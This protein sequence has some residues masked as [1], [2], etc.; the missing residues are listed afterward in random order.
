MIR[1]TKAEAEVI[2]DLKIQPWFAI[3]P[4]EIKDGSFILPDDVMEHVKPFLK[5][6]KAK[7]KIDKLELA[8]KDK[9]VRKLKDS[10]KR[11]DPEMTVRTD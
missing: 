4:V 9:P 3:R 6:P 7:K 2:G 1:L 11:T 5:D 8:V 10:E